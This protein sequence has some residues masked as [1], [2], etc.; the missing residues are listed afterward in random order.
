MVHL[1]ESDWLASQNMLLPPFLLDNAA[2]GQ[3]PN[4]H[5]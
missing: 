4:T 5:C 1:T 3:N 2:I